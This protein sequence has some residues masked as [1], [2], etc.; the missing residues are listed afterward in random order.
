MKE[1]GVLL[2]GIVIL[3]MSIKLKTVE[4]RVE[5]TQ[6]QAEIL[7]VY[8]KAMPECRKEIEK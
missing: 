4:D 3:I 2:M 5:L 8:C 1:L 7:T 6:E